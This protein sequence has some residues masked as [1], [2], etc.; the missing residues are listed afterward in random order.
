MAE[1]SPNTPAWPT[2][3]D[4]VSKKRSRPIHLPADILPPSP[5][6]YLPPYAFPRKTH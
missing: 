2:E 5:G 6:V 3:R 1:E 4:S